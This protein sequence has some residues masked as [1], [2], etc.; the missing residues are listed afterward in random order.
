MTRK[1]V[2]IAA[3]IAATALS[4]CS[5]ISKTADSL[6][7]GTKSAAKFVSSPVTKLL[8]DTPE[9]DYQFD[10]ADYE[11]VLYEPEATPV[12]NDNDY[13]VELYDTP[14][15]RPAPVQTYVMA[16]DPRD[17]S[18]VRLNGESDVSDWRS[19]EMLHKGY[20]FTDETS[21]MLNPEFE[22]C[23]RNRGYVVE[24]E[25]AQY[26]TYGTGIDADKA[27]FAR[28]ATSYTSGYSYP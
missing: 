19:C 23:M 18:F 1:H 5:Q 14:A 6:W 26:G 16:S 28:P 3:L 9:Q 20:L 17:V 8:R 24:A 2:L 27:G 25:V 12:Y 10:D 11:V 4:G 22:V 7:G 13:V 21:L 15:L